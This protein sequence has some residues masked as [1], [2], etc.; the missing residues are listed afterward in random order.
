[1]KKLTYEEKQNESI[2][3]KILRQAKKSKFLKRSIK[4]IEM[5][6]SECEQL[7]KRLRLTD[8]GNL[9]YLN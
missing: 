4:K 6:D 9:S 1:M 5:S 7:Q 3:E 8:E 2:E